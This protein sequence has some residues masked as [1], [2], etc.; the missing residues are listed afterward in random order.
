MRT[1]YLHH[2]QGQPSNLTIVM[3]IML[4][5]VKV[6]CY[7][8]VVPTILFQIRPRCFIMELESPNYVRIAMM[9]TSVLYLRGLMGSYYWSS[10]LEENKGSWV[11]FM[12]WIKVSWM[13]TLLSC[14]TYFSTSSLINYE[15]VDFS[16]HDA[17]LMLLWLCILMH[18]TLLEGY[19]AAQADLISLPTLLKSEKVFTP[20]KKNWPWTFNVFAGFL[21]SL[22]C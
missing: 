22:I 3:A 20:V 10:G 17:R 4:P 6:A 2:S 12:G 8:E 13:I 15:N 11:S 16:L 14:S 19:F 9:L 7:S 5:P 18:L 1:A 21:A